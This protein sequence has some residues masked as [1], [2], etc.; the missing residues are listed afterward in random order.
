[1]LGG[2]GKDNF[3]SKQNAIY[4]INRRPLYLSCH[5]RIW[6]QGK[7]I[8][9][10]VNWFLII[11]FETLRVSQ[12]YYTGIE[13]IGDWLTIIM[14]TNQYL[15]LIIG[16]WANFCLIYSLLLRNCRRQIYVFPFIFKVKVDLFRNIHLLCDRIQGQGLFW[17]SNWL[18]FNRLLSLIGILNLIYRFV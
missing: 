17:D 2:M 1:M 9:G 15:C 11:S 4:D 8:K 14:L 7:D 16:E 13:E 5:L 3:G 6:T 18:P 10:R 12:T